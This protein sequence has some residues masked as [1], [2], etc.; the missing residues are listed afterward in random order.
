M[1]SVKSYDEKM[2]SIPEE[3]KELYMRNQE[4]I[5][6]YLKQGKTIKDIEELL[7]NE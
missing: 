3:K 2:V 6:M 4:I 1:M 5:N 7:K